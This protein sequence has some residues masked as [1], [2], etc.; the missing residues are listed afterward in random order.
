MMGTALGTGMSTVTVI[1]LLCSTDGKKDDEKMP[2]RDR[3]ASP[4]AK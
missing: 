1:G 3:E 4:S 2:E